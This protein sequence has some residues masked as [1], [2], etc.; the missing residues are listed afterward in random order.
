MPGEGLRIVGGR[1]RGR[2]IEVPPGDGV[3][4]TSDRIREALFNILMHRD[5][6]PDGGSLVDD[7]TVLDAFAGSGALALEALSRGA[8]RAFAFENDRAAGRQVLANARALGEA[9]RLTLIPADALDPPA[10]RAKAD[11]I[12]LDPPYGRDLVAPALTGL[13]HRGWIAP[14]AVVV[15]ETDRTERLPPLA[16][17]ERLA[18]KT[19]GKTR[20]VFLR[21]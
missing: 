10:A 4:P 9:W 16:G 20:L 5:W 2:R 15:A 8:A 6:G 14:G 7:A 13:R 12:F 18:E 19:Y 1:H 17:L 3:R 21:A 11:L